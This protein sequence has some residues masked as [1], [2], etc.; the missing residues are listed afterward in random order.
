MQEYQIYSDKKPNGWFRDFI[1]TK[2]YS[3][4]FVLCDSNT[5]KV[6]LPKFSEMLNDTEKNNLNVISI[7]SGEPSKDLNGAVRVWDELM[8]SNADRHSLLINL[9]GGMI[10]DLGG[11]VAST[12]K[13][14]IS[15]INV[16][17]SLLAMVDASIGGKTGINYNNVKNLLGTFSNPKM[18]LVYPPFLKTLDQRQFMSGFAEMIKHVLISKS[19]KINIDDLLKMDPAELINHPAYIKHSLDVKKKIVDSDPYDN[20]VRKKL[21]FGHTIG[22]ALESLF[23]NRKGQEL[24]HG[25]AVA[26]GMIVELILSVEKGG[27]KKPIADQLIYRINELYSKPIL[28]EGDEKK[29]IELMQNDKKN[30]SGIIKCVLIN[31][32]GEAVC[33]IALTDSEI[34]KAF[35][36]Y[37]S[38]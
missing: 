38:L 18:T 22:H 3:K 28:Q 29:L 11:F 20:S 10:C 37:Q 27:M 23:M 5:L 35:K 9:G 16:P 33:D 24:L 7:D 12:Y 2:K 21:N 19:S 17:T 13:R 25:E 36:L 26:Q 30:R 34:L 15:F 32:T 14:G 31:N 4:L 6:C 1:Q 8:K